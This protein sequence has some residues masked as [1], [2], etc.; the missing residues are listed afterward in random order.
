VKLALPAQL[1]QLGPR[2]RKA[3]KDPWVPRVPSGSAGRL[4]LP[5][6]PDRSDRRARKGKP[7]A[8]AQSDPAA[9]ADRQGRRAS[10]AQPAPHRQ[11]ASSPVRIAS[12]AETTKSLQ[13]L[14]ARAVRRTERGARP[15][16]RQQPVYAY[17]GDLGHSVATSSVFSKSTIKPLHNNRFLADNSW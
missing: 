3:S 7:V 17:A 6:R 1:V 8:K 13:G 16:A 2:A 5:D 11:F 14:F 4:V 9:N 10:L 12:V 15:L